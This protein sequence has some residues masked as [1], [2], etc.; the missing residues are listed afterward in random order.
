[1]KTGNFIVRL[2]LPLSSVLRLAAGLPAG[3]VV[4][5]GFNTPGQASGIPSSPSAIRSV[6][7]AGNLLTGV[8]GIAAGAS[9]GLALKR[10]GTVVGWGWNNGGQATGSK[11]SNPD[12]A[13]GSVAIRGHVLT[14]VKSISAGRTHSLALTSN[15]TVVAWGQ[16]MYGAAN[17]PS[18][19][20]NVVAISAGW[21]DS[22]AL[23][24]DG[25]VISW[26]IPKA[27]LGLSNVVAI[28][29][30]RGTYAINMVLKK[31]G[32]VFAWGPN[33]LALPVPRAVTNVIAVA[34]GG[35]H[36][37]ALRRDGTVFG[38]G[39]NNAAQ[40]TGVPTKKA[41]FY[42][43]GLVM[44]NG[45]CLTNMVA[46]AAGFESSLALGSDGTVVEWG[47]IAPHA[48]VSNAVAI[49]AGKY[50]CLA[51]TTN[52]TEVAGFQSHK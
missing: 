41:P 34:S 38:W 10:D 24:S 18:G 30:G 36:C 39:D 14:N 21:T 25:T 13:S 52:G 20:S 27:P 40:A 43:A 1:M 50:F 37:L 9:H 51:I 35:G 49:V 28:A 11:S 6:T 48:G 29:A 26:G 46:I 19:L 23:K 8:V 47:H 22:L 33:G 3:Q 32:T 42:S 16:N 45:N 2:L 7:V 17:V 12:W 5:W 44:R 15:G 4:E 31:E